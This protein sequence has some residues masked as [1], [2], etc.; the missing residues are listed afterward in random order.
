MEETEYQKHY[1]TVV[2]D[3][4][5][6]KFNFKNK[7]NIPKLSK[8]IVSMGLA[9]ASNDKQ[10]LQYCIG[11]LEIITGQKPYVTKAKKS[12]S[13]FKLREDQQIGAMVTLRGKRMYDFMFKL[14]H[15]SAPRIPDF[16]GLKRKC[17]GRG[18]YSMGLKDQTVFPEVNLDKMKKSQGMN[19][20]FVTTASTDEECVE[21]LE[22]M[23]MPFKKK[24]G[25]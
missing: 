21:F 19:I 12:I 15:I 2:I 13:N 10:L 25:N 16:R 1:K 18:N 22:M 17:D 6:K 23:G 24:T 11:D 14:I 5:Q 20:T 3:G 9:V 4:L 7:H 8:I